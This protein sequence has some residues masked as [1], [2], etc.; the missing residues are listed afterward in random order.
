MFDS[1]AERRIQEAMSRGEFDNLPGRGKPLPKDEIDRLPEEMRMAY[2]ILKNSGYI[3]GAVP[4]PEQ[5]DSVDPLIDRCIAAEEEN[6]R[7]NGKCRKKIKLFMGKTGTKILQGRYCNSI[8][9]KI[10]GR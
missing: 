8:I 1:I 9:K 4:R 6:S 10:S 3:E 5:T 2:I 7:N